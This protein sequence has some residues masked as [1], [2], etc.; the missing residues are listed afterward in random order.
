MAGNQA[1][2]TRF[3]GF[4]LVAVAAAL[5]AGLIELALASAGRGEQGWRE[6]VRA[7]AALSLGLFLVVYLASTLRRL[8]P[9]PATSWLLANRR[10]LGVSFAVV[11]FAHFGSIVA[12]SRVL[13]ASPPLHLAVLGGI[14]DLLLLAMVATSFDATA[15]RLGERRWIWLHR[16]G[17]HYVWVIFAF[18]YGGAAFASDRLFPGVA[19]A[20]LL[21]ALALRVAVHLRQ[22]TVPLASS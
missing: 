9:G 7:T 6:A 10:Y 2:P 4:R 8:V 15:E 12:L 3:G 20:A 21:G 13:G 16:V 11:H 17:L 19:I 5:A 1:R 22:R 14:G 18:T